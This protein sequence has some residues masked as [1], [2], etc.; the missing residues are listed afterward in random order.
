[1]WLSLVLTYASVVPFGAHAGFVAPLT[2]SVWFV[3]SAF[4][5]QMS[6]LREKAIFVPSGDQ[7]ASVPFEMRTPALDPSASDWQTLR[8]HVNEISPFAPGNAPWAAPSRPRAAVPAAA[9]TSRRRTRTLYRV[10]AETAR[11]DAG[12]TTQPRPRRRRGRGAR[13]R[14]S[15]PAAPPRRRQDRGMPRAPAARSGAARGRARGGS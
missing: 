12:G 3:P 9:S 6:P 4:A 11:Y 1:M 5:V 15:A 13:A 7:T 10:R 8:P 14:A 2:N